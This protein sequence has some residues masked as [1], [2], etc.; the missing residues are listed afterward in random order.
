MQDS[1]MF[2]VW[3]RFWPL[4]IIVSGLVAVLYS[5]VNK[6]IKMEMNVKKYLRMAKLI[7][8]NSSIWRRMCSVRSAAW[9]PRCVMVSWESLIRRPVAFKAIF[10]ITIRYCE[11]SIMRFGMLYKK[12]RK[13]L[14]SSIRWAGSCCSCVKS[15]TFFVFCVYGIRLWR[16]K[17]QIRPIFPQ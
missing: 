13:W 17:D 11:W 6:M 9:W 3:M 2:R 5:R 12:K 15:L 7:R 1:A 16:L 10:T 8:L 4:S 14:T